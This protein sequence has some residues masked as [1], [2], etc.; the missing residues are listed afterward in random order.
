MF[1]SDSTPI[2]SA[3]PPRYFFLFPDSTR[4]Q[5]K[6]ALSISL[7]HR[8]KPLTDSVL[9]PA[10]SPGLL[11]AIKTKQVCLRQRVPGEAADSGGSQHSVLPAQMLARPRPAQ[12]R[13]SCACRAA[14]A[15]ARSPR[16]TWA[17]G[18]TEQLPTATGSGSSWRV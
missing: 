15:K 9:Q 10:S 18:S 6:T 14:N 17:A 3:I 2:L 1:C 16:P 7:P 5:K 8:E 12:P 13:F 4:R 11:Q